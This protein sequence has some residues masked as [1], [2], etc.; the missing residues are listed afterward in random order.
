M[1][2]SRQEFGSEP[3]RVEMAVSLPKGGVGSAAY[4]SGRFAAAA[5]GAA[6]AAIAIASSWGKAP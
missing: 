4:S 5:S 1:Q 3:E 6:A 2:T